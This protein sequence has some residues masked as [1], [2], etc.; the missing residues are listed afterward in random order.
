MTQN[1][2]QKLTRLLSLVGM[3]VVASSVFAEQYEVAAYV[4]PAYQPEPRW[5]ELGIF[6]AGKRDLGLKAYF[7]HSSV[8]WDQNPRLPPSS[9]A[10][11]VLGSSP[12]KFEASLRRVKDWSDK[13]TPQGYPHLITI[14][15]WNEWTEGSYLEPDEKFGFGYLNAVKK[16]FVE[17]ECAK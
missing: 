2:Y 7:V 8:G 4:W 16:V 10:S 3:A 11:T 6:G 12:E 13:N 14:N 1:G 5:A 17:G 15:S 9:V